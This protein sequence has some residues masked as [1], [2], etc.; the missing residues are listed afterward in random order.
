MD[1]GGK[2]T[3]KNNPWPRKWV[4]KEEAMTLFPDKSDYDR[5]V[6]RLTKNL[7]NSESLKKLRKAL[8]EG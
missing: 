7:E 6:I 2:M 8:R 1:V 3:P 4:T 5:E